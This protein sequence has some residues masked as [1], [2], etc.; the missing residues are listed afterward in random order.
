MDEGEGSL[1]VSPVDNKEA[2]APRPVKK[3]EVQSPEADKLPVAFEGSEYAKLRQQAKEGGKPFVTLFTDI[4]GTFFKRGFEEAS[5]Q[6]SETSKKF[7]VPIVAITGRNFRDVLDRIETPNHPE[8]NL[9]Y[10][11]V[12]AGS[13][14]TEIWVLQV[15]EDGKKT[16]VRD[17]EFIKQ[18]V[19]GAYDRTSVLGLSQMLI[20]QIQQIHP[21][22]YLDFQNPDLEKA[23]NQGE[24]V[25]VESHK[26]S[27]NAYLASDQEVL[28][29]RGQ[30]EARFPDQK[31]IISVGDRPDHLDEGRKHYNIDVLPA[32][33]ADAVNYIREETDVDA[34]FVAGNGGNDTAMLMESGD[35]SIG[36][37]GSDEEIDE[38]IR[39]VSPKRKGK[40]SFARSENPEDNGKL[41]YLETGDRTGPESII[42]AAK[43]IERAVNIKKISEQKKNSSSS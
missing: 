25:D 27:F 4:D 6:I 11:D 37:G 31:V 14:G 40:K 36:V 41:Y 3:T 21:E 42:Y 9:P 23:F 1:E 20:D 43:V 15:G 38:S 17:D 32:T 19:G 2:D 7:G 29:M 10:F 28:S 34:A 16:Y 24:D 18:I 5:D 30:L 22:R 13:V 12:I 8:M 26:V 35:L 39:E 33:K